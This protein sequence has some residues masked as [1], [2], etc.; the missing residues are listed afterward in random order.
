MTITSLQND[1]VKLAHS[2]QTRAKARRKSGQIVLEGSRLIQ[3]ALAQGIK[4]DFVL[5]LSDQADPDIIST[6][7]Q[8]QSALITVDEAVM[9]HVSD[10]QHPQGIVAVCPLPS[11]TLPVSLYRLVILDGVGDPGNAGTIIRSAAASGADAVIFAPG[12][13]D[14]YNPKTLRAGM[15]AHFRLPV[16]DMKWRD[17]HTTCAPLTVYAAIGSGDHRYDQVAW[18]NP[19]AIIIGSEAHGTSQAAQE[20]ADSTVFI[21]MAADTESLNAAMA[22]SVLLF[23]SQRH[24]LTDRPDSL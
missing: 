12:S 15:G 6:L 2:L 10:T 16:L 9:A 4:P 5:Y 20:L 13:V 1:K 18:Q 17:L 23:E 7:K 3:D 24:Y 8:A 21:P 14:P 22:A 19:H 11:A